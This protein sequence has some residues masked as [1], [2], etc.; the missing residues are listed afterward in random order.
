MSLCVCSLIFHHI[1]ASLTQTI[2]L[3][4]DFAEGF[5]HRPVTRQDAAHPGS[6][7]REV[8][9]V[10]VQ[11]PLQDPPPVAHVPVC[12][13]APGRPQLAVPQH[14]CSTGTGHRRH[15][16]TV[17][18]FTL[19]F[20]GAHRHKKP[21]WTHSGSPVL[22]WLEESEAPLPTLPSLLWL[23]QDHGHI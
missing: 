12:C 14:H 7:P 3:S 17:N 22:V 9:P 8:R 15:A 19:S 11:P 21:L 2:S 5:P 18:P 20:P 4:A 23:L 16:G 1:G 13:H 6:N 10:T